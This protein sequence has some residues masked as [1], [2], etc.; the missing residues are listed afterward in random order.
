MT[1]TDWR[2]DARAAVAMDRLV[3]RIDQISGLVENGSFSEAR[4]NLSGRG[5]AASIDVA[6]VPA[7]VL[8]RAQAWMDAADDSLR[9]ADVVAD[10]VKRSLGMARRELTG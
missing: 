9:Q 1:E 7:D 8:G 3:G 6:M 5:W 4:S 2:R 10:C